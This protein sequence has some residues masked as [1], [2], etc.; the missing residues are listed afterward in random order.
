M[1][2]HRHQSSLLQAGDSPDI[3]LPSSSTSDPH[4][5]SAAHLKAHR[6]THHAYTHDHVQNHYLS[7]NSNDNADPASASASAPRPDP[8]LSDSHLD[9]RASSDATSLDPRAQAA[10]VDAALA[11]RA[12]DT[13]SYITQI[14]QTISVIQVVDISGSPISTQTQ[15]AQPNTVVLDP[16]SGETI[17]QSD[18]APTIALDPSSLIPNPGSLLP[19]PGQL[20]SDLGIPSSSSTSTTTS[21]LTTTSTS[22]KPSSAP[23]PASAGFPTFGWQRLQLDVYRECI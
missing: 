8:I 23:I 3:L 10:A 20:L 5:R 16:A 2:N 14:V 12:D 19:D 6:H 18:P 22:S 9:E 15:Y 11:V 4:A 13:L 1:T 7:D 21:T 17:S